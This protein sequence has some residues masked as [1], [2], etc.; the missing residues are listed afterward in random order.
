[1]E[2]DKFKAAVRHGKFGKNGTVLATVLRQRMGPTDISAS[3]KGK[4]Y[5]SATENERVL[6]ERKPTADNRQELLALME[7]DTAGGR[8]SRR[9]MLMLPR[10]C[11]GTRVSWT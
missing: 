6:R 3:C 8:G 10:S 7:R 11:V 9:P 4:Q 1:M 2:Y 5:G